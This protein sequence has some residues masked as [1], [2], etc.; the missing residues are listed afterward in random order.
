MNF[1][2]KE[3]RRMRNSLKRA[4]RR[5]YWAHT[6]I[7]HMTYPPLKR[8]VSVVRQGGEKLGTYINMPMKVS[9]KFLC[10]RVSK[11]DSRMKPAPP[12][13]E[14]IMENTE[15]ILCEVVVSWTSIPRC[16]AHLSATKPKSNSTTDAVP[17]DIKSGFKVSAPTSD[18]YLSQYQ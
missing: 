1:I 2:Q 16:R 8:C 11:M 4:P 9:C 13:K 7:A 5:W 10:L 6:N 3:I 14:K 15:R 17:I 18:M 12:I